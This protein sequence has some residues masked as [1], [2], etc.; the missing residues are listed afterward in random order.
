MSVLSRQFSVPDRSPRSQT[1]F[2][3]AY[4]RSSASPACQTAP[5]LPI[6]NG[7][8]AFFLNHYMTCWAE[9]LRGAAKQSFEDRRDQAGAWSRECKSLH[10]R[11]ELASLQNTHIARILVPILPRGFHMVSHCRNVGLNGRY[12]QPRIVLT[13]S[14][15]VVHIKNRHRP[16]CSN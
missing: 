4:P 15:H 12:P 14:Q 2:G 1:P 13:D 3:T 6:A 9:V 5:Y 16:L 11:R 7:H 8:H 10:T